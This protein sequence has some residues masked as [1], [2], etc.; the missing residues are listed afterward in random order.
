MNVKEHG[1]FNAS[2]D[3]ALEVYKL[4]KNFPKEEIYRLVSQLRRAAS[5]IPMNLVEGAACNGG[6]DFASFVSGALGSC[7][8]VMY[9]LFLA[10]DLGYINAEN[11][12]SIEDKYE[13]V[14]IMLSELFLRVA[15]SS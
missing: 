12:K 15:E 10:K 13:R 14:R 7:E 9:Q 11:Y 8:E 4:T 5:S 1:V 3:M 2:R 6:E